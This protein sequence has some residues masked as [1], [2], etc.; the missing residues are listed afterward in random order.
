MVRE[1]VHVQVGQCG[2]QIGNAFWETMR[3]EH[4]LDG[5][6]KFQ[7]S[8]DTAA[9]ES[10]LDKIDVYFQ[11]SGERRFVPRAALIDLEPG[12]LDVI[13]SNEIGKMF[14]PDNFVF[15]ASGAGNNWAKGHY[16]EGAELIDEV[17]DVVRKETEGCDCPQGFQ[18]THSLGGGTG[19]GLGTL[20]LLK[21]RDNY[22][23][24]ITCTF[25]V[26]PSPKVSDVV[27]EPYN[28]T[29]SIHQLLENSDETFAIDNEAL[30][31]ISHNV[32]KQQQPRYKDLNWVISLVMSGITSSLR[33]PGKLNGDLRKLGVNLVPFPRLHFF[34][35]A[36]SP[37]FAPGE[38]S[39]VKLTVQELTDQM[40]SSRNFLANVKP[41]DGKYMS[42]SCTYRGDLSTQEV[43][44]QVAQVQSK[45]Q[46]DFVTW[47][48]NNIKSSIIRIPPEGTTMSGTFVANTTA[49]KSIFQRISAQF[50]RMYKRRAFLHWYKGEGMDEMEFQEADK[51]VRD[52]VTEYQDKQDA[53]V[54][55]DEEEDNQEDDEQQEDVDE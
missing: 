4:H 38:G 51:N 35:M 13:K 22:P 45:M 54:E 55:L 1:I 50:A 36:Q 49:I 46:E 29:L 15:G 41:E 33:F 39:R 19:S 16:T 53:V 52:L 6:G 37:L 11:E 30:Y 3:K 32:L 20:L 25:S 18:L 48:P 42:A 31:N 28:A 2:N 17:V 24:R 40:W 7:A 5:S 10:L 14:K 21:I 8:E 23:D 9:D 34:L 47:I 43:D 12:T 26:Y 27:V 44:D